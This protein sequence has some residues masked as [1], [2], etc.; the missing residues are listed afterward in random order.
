M[1]SRL[2][3]I[4]G[5]ARDDAEAF[6]DAWK[7][8]EQGEPIESRVIAFESWEGLSAIMTGDR[9][10]LL[11]HLHATP[12]P[13]SEALARSLGR[14]R[15]DVAADIDALEGAGLIERS[16]RRL[17]VTTDSIEAEIRL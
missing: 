9:L 16:G 10:S 15:A 3:L 12:E 14:D 5:T 7:R 2:K 6:A 8:A 11:R 4:V 1:S 13:S 17:R